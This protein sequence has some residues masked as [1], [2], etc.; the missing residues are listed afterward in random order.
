M[1]EATWYRWLNQYGGEKAE[2]TKRT[3][4][5][6]KENARLKKLLADQVL[7]IDILNEVARGKF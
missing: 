5:L 7:A 3:K 4:E 6:E 1:T 2:S